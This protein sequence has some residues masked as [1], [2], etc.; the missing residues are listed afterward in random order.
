M[1][2]PKVLFLLVVSLV[3]ANHSGGQGVQVI[4]QGAMRDNNDG[5]IKTTI[6]TASTALQSL[7]GLPTSW[8][9]GIICCLVALVILKFAVSAAMHPYGL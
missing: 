4:G 5:S 6:T 2:V 8:T 3:F 9:I 1:L 7:L